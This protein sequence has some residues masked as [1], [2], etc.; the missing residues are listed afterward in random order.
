MPALFLI[1]IISVDPLLSST[2][3]AFK[4]HTGPAIFLPLWLKILLWLPSTLGI[5][6]K[7]YQPTRACLVFEHYLLSYRDLVFGFSF[8][9]NTKFVSRACAPGHLPAAEALSSASYSHHSPASYP[10]VCFSQRP[11]CSRCCGHPDLGISLPTPTTDCP[12]CCKGLAAVNPQL[13]ALGGNALNCKEP[14]TQGHTPFPAR[15]TD[16]SSSIVLTAS[17]CGV[18]SATLLPARPC[19]NHS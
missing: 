8:L 16:R 5:M 7:L 3:K 11:P 17:N 4:E 18:S 19:V 13:S 6:D 2:R 15:H 10:C 9:K 1:L 14:L 12:S